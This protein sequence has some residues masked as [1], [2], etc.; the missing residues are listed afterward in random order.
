M[1]VPGV[2]KKWVTWMSVSKPVANV[3]KVAAKWLAPMPIKIWYP[4]VF[5]ADGLR[6]NPPT[7]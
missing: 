6:G 2:V 3:P 4:R 7:K 5:L 1:P